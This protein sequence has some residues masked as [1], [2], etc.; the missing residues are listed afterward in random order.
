M[1]DPQTPPPQVSSLRAVISRTQA[2]V[3]PPNRGTAAAP[4]R[5]LRHTNTQIGRYQHLPVQAFDSSSLNS[6]CPPVSPPPHTCN[7]HMFDCRVSDGD[8]NWA[9]MSPSW[10]SRAQ[11]GGSAN[12]ALGQRRFRRHAVTHQRWTIKLEG[13]ARG[14][15]Q[16]VAEV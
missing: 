14:R 13:R 11:Q 16:E 2:N 7:M 6:Q 9:E 5:L 12:H 3:C 8:R 10:R 1:R 4:T 15:S